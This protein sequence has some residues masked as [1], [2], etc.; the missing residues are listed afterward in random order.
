M[1]FQVNSLTK[2]LFFGAILLKRAMPGRLLTGSPVRM[3]PVVHSSFLLYHEAMLHDRNLHE[4]RS[5]VLLYH[6]AMLHDRDLHE[7]RSAVLLYHVQNQ[8]MIQ[9]TVR[10]SCKHVDSLALI[11]LQLFC[12]LCQTFFDLRHH[13]FVSGKFVLLFLHFC[14]RCFA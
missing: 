13:L 2:C 10:Q 11:T 8:H 3:K 14:F 1:L 5:A 7:L 9:F 6:E 4:L 12:H